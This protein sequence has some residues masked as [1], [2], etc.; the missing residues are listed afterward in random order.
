MSRNAKYYKT[1]VTETTEY[2]LTFIPSDSSDVSGGYTEL[3]SECIFE[4]CII[5][6]NFEDDVF[7]G[8][9]LADTMDIEIDLLRAGK[10][11]AT[12]Q[13]FAS[14]IDTDL[15]SKTVNGVSMSIP[16]LWILEK[17]AAGAANWNPGTAT[18]LF[19]GCQDSKPAIEYEIKADAVKAKIKVVS[20][21]R[22]AME[23]TTIDM[24]KPVLTGLPWAKSTGNIWVLK[25]NDRLVDYAYSN[26]IV[27]SKILT[28]EII[29][30]DTIENLMISIETN[31]NNVIEALTRGLYSFEF[32]DYGD[33]IASWVFLKPDFTQSHNDYDLTIHPD[34]A[35]LDE[36]TLYYI[37]YAENTDAS[38]LT[39]V[40]GLF[41]SNTKNPTF[42]EYKNIWDLFKVLA[43]NFGVKASFSYAATLDYIYLNFDK[44]LDVTQTAP[45]LAK[46]DIKEVFELFR[47]GENTVNEVIITYKDTKGEDIE[48][49]TY[50]GFWTQAEGSYEIELVLHNGA[51]AY[52]GEDYAGAAPVINKYRYAKNNIAWRNLYCTTTFGGVDVWAKVGG[53]SR[54]IFE[55]ISTSVDTTTVAAPDTNTNNTIFKNNIVT[56]ANARQLYSSMAYPLAQGL[57]YI[58]G[59]PSQGLITIKVNTGVI[60]HRQLGNMVS[61]DVNTMIDGYSFNFKEPGDFTNNYNL[62]IT[63]VKSNYINNESEVTLFIRGDG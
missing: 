37:P 7:V 17:R 62:V 2:R 50:G 23:R 41:D 29:R 53:A 54:Y 30:F 51:M 46:T 28:A 16:N 18:I 38:V 58:F 63:A 40:A 43:E 15:V 42:F 20:L 22:A 13:N 12:A 24:I 27:Y 52:E 44:L 5:E 25:N 34:D 11:T 33:L 3:P 14:Y 45:T 61:F 59:N 8:M 9:P 60:D 1:W 4:Q 56:N 10:G 35:K 49:V 19:I 36:T 39:T 55:T 48:D 47:K 6:S 26:I 57:N 21:L 31:L 32:Q